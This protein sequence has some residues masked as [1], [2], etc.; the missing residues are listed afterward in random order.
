MAPTARWAAHRYEACGH[1]VALLL[2][3]DVARRGAEMAV[4]EDTLVPGDLDD[5]RAYLI[6]FDGGAR[7]AAGQ[8][9]RRAAGA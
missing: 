8:E 4:D 7:E 2:A 5:P 3:T 6:T 9:G 1:Y